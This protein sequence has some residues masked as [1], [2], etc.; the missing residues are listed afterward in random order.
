MNGNYRTYLENNE[1]LEWSI[2]WD[3]IEYVILLTMVITKQNTVI[4]HTI[5]FPWYVRHTM[6]G[7]F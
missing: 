3:E 5:Q 1:I 7:L 2:G 4:W 6:N